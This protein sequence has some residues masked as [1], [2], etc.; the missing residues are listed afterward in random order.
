[1][2]TFVLCAE[3]TNLVHVA[4]WQKQKQKFAS[5]R[6]EKATAGK[7]GL[8]FPVAQDRILKRKEAAALFLVPL[9]PLGHAC[10]IDR[11][12]HNKSDTSCRKT[13][14]PAWPH[15]QGFDSHMSY[16][17]GHSVLIP[18]C[19]TGARYRNTARVVPAMSY[20]HAN[21]PSVTGRSYA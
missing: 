1:M 14:R 10:Q 8:S 15:S 6:T 12:A 11:T 9:N 17:R 4:V 3:S 5:A 16:C 21:N 13:C 7:N 18:T 19:F 20:R 2:S